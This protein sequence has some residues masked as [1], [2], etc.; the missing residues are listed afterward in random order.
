V[1]DTIR[2]LVIVIQATRTLRQIAFPVK[3]SK[4]KQS[5]SLTVTLLLQYRT[6]T[7]T[8]ILKNS[9][10]ISEDRLTIAV[11]PGTLGLATNTVL[12]SDTP[13]HP[14]SMVVGRCD[15]IKSNFTK[16]RR[17]TVH[18]TTESDSC[19]TDFTPS[20]MTQRH[21]DTKK[22]TIEHPDRVKERAEPGIEPGTSPILRESIKL[23]GMNPKGELYH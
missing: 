18:A 4:A 1:Y 8:S 22:M 17:V 20:P 3:Q 14:L 13:Q 23:P 19:L 12:L 21:V 11:H 9:L 10:G 2:Y 7:P 6:H 15:A 5:R 16:S